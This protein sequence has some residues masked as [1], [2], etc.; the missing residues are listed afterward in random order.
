[1]TKQ[2]WVERAENVEVEWR[3][4]IDGSYVEAQSGKTREKI[5]PA[6]GSVLANVADCE[7][8]DVDLAVAAAR[9]AFESGEWAESGPRHRREVLVA[10]ADLIVAHTEE[11]ALL[12]TL[13][14][15]KPISDS[16]GEVG[17]SARAVRFYAE[18]IDKVAGQVMPTEPEFVTLVTKEAAGVAACITPW[19]YPL[20]QVCQKIAPAL[21]VG[22]SVLL[23]PSERA[24]LVA[25][26]LAAL[27]AEAGIPAGVLNVLPGLGST[28]GQAISLHMDVDK[29]SFT[30]S[31]GVGKKLLQAAGQSNLKS[32]SLECGGK[33]PNIVHRDARGLE[34]VAKVAAEVA[35]VNQGEMCNAGT[36]LLV[37]E[38]IY[39]EFMGHLAAA[40]QG[41]LPG[42]PLDPT[43]KTGAMVDAAHVA[44]VSSYVESGLS[45][46][47]KIVVG[48]K[49]EGNYFE[50]TIFEG[51]S[52]SMRIASEEIFGPVLSVIKYS[53]LDEAIRIANDTQ[54]GLAAAIWTTDLH[55]AHSASRKLR[56]GVVYV[57]C[58]DV[59][60]MSTPFGGFKQSGLGREKSLMAMEE[61]SETKS[62][63]IKF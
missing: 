48:G 62:T 38:D 1:M 37:H 44:A 39:D 7:A 28:A 50:P 41:W 8:A 6:D 36:R 22:N 25:I 10:F 4:F 45:E 20:S 49:S 23:K 27:A 55:T 14:M 30:G 60:E 53:S 61:F 24:P 46:G 17:S 63:W 59:A 51:V 52:N 13:D 33:S 54:Y 2:N 29:I 58:Y 34:E 11:L 19:N 5:N 18:A 12:I 35:F 3:A 15:G 16:I 57:N 47:A 43:A 42:D 56:A 40:S 31:T 9:K 21:A 32:V 26:R